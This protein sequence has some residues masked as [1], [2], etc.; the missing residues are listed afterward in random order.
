MFAQGQEKDRGPGP[1]PAQ[2]WS[3][4][5]PRAIGPGSCSWSPCF[6]VV[7]YLSSGSWARDTSRS[8]L[9]AAW[10]CSRSRLQSPSLIRISAECSNDCRLSPKPRT[11]FRPLVPN[12]A[13]SHREDKAASVGWG[14]TVLRA[15]GGRA[16]SSAGCRARFSLTHTACT[17][18]CCRR[19]E[20]WGWCPCCGS[21]CKH[22]ACCI[23]RR[24]AG[25]DSYSSAILRVGLL[26]IPTFLIAQITLEFNR[27][28][29]DGLHAVHLRAG[30][31]ARG[32]GG[33]V[34]DRSHW[35][36]CQPPQKSAIDSRRRAA[37]G[38]IVNEH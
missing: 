1:R 29:H 12:M 27:A 36:G 31:F 24:R 26:L 21:S 34:L 17:C 6:G 28:A 5:W 37:I 11:V 10:R 19:S 2:T 13:R 9:W 38:P 30:R 14:R 33:S 20:S 7:A 32:C 22:G 25:I 16:S 3:V 4:S 23:G 8:I 18:S 35:R 15:P